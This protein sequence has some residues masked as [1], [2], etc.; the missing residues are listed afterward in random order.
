MKPTAKLE[1]VQILKDLCN[2]AQFVRE[3]F[4]DIRGVIVFVVL[5]AMAA[6]AIVGG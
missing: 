6:I 5:A 3:F 4:W 1:D 2:F